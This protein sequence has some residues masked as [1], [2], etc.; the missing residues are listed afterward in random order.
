MKKVV[1]AVLAMA[2]MG[3]AEAIRVV[4]PP[5]HTVK[6]GKNA[7]SEQ[8]KRAGEKRVGESGRKSPSQG[9]KRHK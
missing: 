4:T 5:P 9:D 7:A 6:A 8:A 3:N 1:F 2:Y